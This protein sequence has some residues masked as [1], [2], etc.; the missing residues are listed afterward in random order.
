MTLTRATQISLVA[1]I[2]STVAQAGVVVYN[3]SS[4]FL[5][6]LATSTTETY[7]SIAIGTVIPNGS[8]VDALTYRFPPQWRKN[9]Q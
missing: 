2:M 9:C 6:A 8:T 7:E 5:S 4:T 1:A 3:S